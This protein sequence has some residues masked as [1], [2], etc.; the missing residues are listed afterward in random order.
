MDEERE[1]GKRNKKGQ[2]KMGNEAYFA[3]LEKFSYV[4]SIAQPK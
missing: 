2:N 3:H 4:I 1:S